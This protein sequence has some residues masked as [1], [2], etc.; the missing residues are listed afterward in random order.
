MKNFDRLTDNPEE[1]HLV[2]QHSKELHPL[3]KNARNEFQTL[4][5]ARI[6]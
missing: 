1:F 4:L 5:N 6:P 2:K 3:E